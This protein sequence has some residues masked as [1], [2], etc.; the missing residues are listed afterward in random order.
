MEYVASIIQ[1][2]LIPSPSWH[3]D[4]LSISEKRVMDGK[5]RFSDLKHMQERV[6]KACR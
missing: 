1:K 2:Q 4:I 6:Q 5:A 3:G